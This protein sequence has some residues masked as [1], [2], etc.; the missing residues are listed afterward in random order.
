MP[1]LPQKLVSRDLSAAVRCRNAE[2]A[3]KAAD[4]IKQSTGNQQVEAFGGDLSSLAQTRKLAE[5]VQE[6]HPSIDVLINNAGDALMCCAHF[7]LLA[8]QAGA[9][10]ALASL[11]AA[12]KLHQYVSCLV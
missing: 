6:A 11:P 9:C 1:R 4:E 7:K 5:A 2:K 8:V 3:Q 12:V 10:S